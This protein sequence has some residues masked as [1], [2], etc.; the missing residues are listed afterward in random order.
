MLFVVLCCLFGQS[1][2]MYVLLRVQGRIRA[3]NPTQH[4]GFFFAENRIQF[5]V[6]VQN[7]KMDFALF[8]TFINIIQRGG[9]ILSLPTMISLTEFWELHPELG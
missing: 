4:K 8:S 5:P 3:R 1:N 9:S 7:S 6:T 2:Y